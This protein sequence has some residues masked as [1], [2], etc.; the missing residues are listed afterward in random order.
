MSVAAI[1]GPRRLSGFAVIVAATAVVAATALLHGQRIVFTSE[2]IV[3]AVIAAAVISYV[4][5]LSTQEEQIR[6]R[7]QKDIHSTNHSLD[8]ETMNN[9]PPTPP[10]VENEEAVRMLLQVAR[11][12]IASGTE[13]PSHALAALL[14][15]IRLTQGED[16]IMRAKE[17]N[18]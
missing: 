8:Q 7:S 10:V 4:Y 14:H 9:H 17:G 12:E 3:F 18:S 5:S 16:G 2:L 13:D 15:C 6:D 11:D 1:D